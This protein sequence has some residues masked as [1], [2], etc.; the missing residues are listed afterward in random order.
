MV[1][2][3]N[4]VQVHFPSLLSELNV[5]VEA[6]T[7]CI[8]AVEWRRDLTATFIWGPTPMVLAAIK[9]VRNMITDCSSFC[10]AHLR[11]RDY[12]QVTQSQAPLYTHSLHFCT[13]A[14][15]LTAVRTHYCALG[16]ARCLTARCL[17][18]LQ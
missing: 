6:L 17:P 5:Q 15:M 7:R 18:L 11:G 1:Q 4:N 3:T 16:D 10:D 13:I 12:A 2:P 8:T 9:E 14:I